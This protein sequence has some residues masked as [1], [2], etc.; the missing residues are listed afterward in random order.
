[1][2]NSIVAGALREIEPLRADE[3]IEGAAKRILAAGV[4]ALPA[5]GKDQQFAGIFGEREFMGAAFPAY[6]RELGSARMVPRRLDEA[7]ELR[8]SC[9]H[10]PIANYLTHNHIIVNADFSDT[11]LAEIFLHHDVLI[12]PVIESG[13]VRAVVTRADFFRA[14][15]ERLV[16]DGGTPG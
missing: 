2:P 6:L 9:R 12:V 14:L 13:Q 8:Q 5:I 7:I 16:G 11:Q 10:E 4:P 1:M 15:M 3:S